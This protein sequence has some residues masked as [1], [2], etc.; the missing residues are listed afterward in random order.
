M[1]KYLTLKQVL[2]LHD[3]VVEKFGGLSGVRD[4]NLLLSCVE[5]PKMT[6]FG[7][8]LYPSIYDKAAVY[9]FNII[10]N[11]PFNDGNKRTG[12]GTAYLF[13]K[14]NEIP[15]LFDDKSYEDLVV[16]VA[17]GTITR[18][19]IAHFLEQETE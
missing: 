17:K 14:A 7:E 4:P 13:L 19:E 15:V 8:D 3:S 5:S 1:I 16:E 11:P 6:M 18:E 2:K 12:A 10:S 9:L